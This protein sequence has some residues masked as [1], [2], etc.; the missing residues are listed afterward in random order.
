MSVP[1]VDPA[2]CAVEATLWRSCLK[3]FDYGPD[4]PKGACENQRLGYYSC[5]KDWTAK[6][7]EGLYDYRKFNLIGACAG[8]AEKLHQCMMVGMFEISNCKEPMAEL[9]R[10]GARHDVAVRQALEG[11]SALQAVDEE[12]QGIKRMWYHAIGKL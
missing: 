1:V 10:C 4:R 12:P 9:K 7:G 6:Q 5:I 11:D 8:E 3:E 2:P